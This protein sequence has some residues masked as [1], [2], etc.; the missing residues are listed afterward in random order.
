MLQIEPTI[1]EVVA[2]LIGAIL[3]GLLAINIWFIRS[4]ARGMQESIRNLVES[5][6]EHTKSISKLSTE[7]AVL[8]SQ[9]E[10][11]KTLSKH[12]RR[13]NGSGR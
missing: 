5:L 11:L 4:M 12:E 7:V 3:S 2:S 8:D 1:L 10:F 13:P 6:D 9:V